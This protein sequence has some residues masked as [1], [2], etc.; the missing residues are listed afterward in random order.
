MAVP[1]GGV[2]NWLWTPAVR[3]GG[4][5]FRG[6]LFMVVSW[7]ESMRQ[8]NERREQSKVKTERVPFVVVSQKMTRSRQ[9]YAK[10]TEFLRDNVFS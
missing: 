9:K 1:G 4:R 3:G 2:T 5:L 6:R 7:D 10:Y 8:N